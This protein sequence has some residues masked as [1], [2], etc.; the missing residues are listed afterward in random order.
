MGVS[1]R[2]NP[3]RILRRAETMIEPG[4]ILNQYRL[5]E[6]IGAGGMGE[7]WAAEDTSLKRRVAVKILP[8]ETADHP[9]RRARF[10]REAQSVA[11]LNHP[12]IVTIHSVEECEGVHFLTM[13]CVDG[14]PLTKRIGKDGLRLDDFFA[15]AIPLAD[16]VAA[17]H[18]QGITHRDLKPDNVMIT[19]DGRVKVLDFGLAKLSATLDD[20]A[21]QETQLQTV[22]REGRIVGTVNYMSPEQAEGKPTD[23]RSDVFSL[24]ILIY[25]MTTGARPFSGD[26]AI[27]T[28]TSILR[29]TPSPIGDLR[30]DLPR[31]L[32]RV[33]RR[34]LAKD[35]DRRYQSALELRNELEELKS[36][37]QS[38]EDLET[39]R[40][41]PQ[42]SGEIA[43]PAAKRFPVW[44]IVVLVAI[45]GLV[46]IVA[47][48]RF[49]SGSRE[50]SGGERTAASRPAATDGPTMIV[51]LPFEN[52]GNPDDEYFADGITEEIT[53]RLASVE[54]L[55]VI[56]RTSAFR[57]D[58]AQKTMAQIGADFGV[59][60]VLEG[61]VRWAGGDGDSRV[62]IIPSLVRVS[63][64]VGVWSEPFNQE[65]SDVFQVQSE[66]ASE[67]VA[68]LGVALA[69]S[70]DGEQGRPTDSPSAYQAYLRGLSTKR[71]SDDRQQW[72]EAAI[73]NFERATE[74][75]PSFALA[76]AELSIAHSRYHH[77]GFDRT[78][79]RQQLAK[80]AVDR[81]L[82]LEPDLP[83]AHKA[84][85]YYHYWSMKDYQPA[86]DAFDVALRDLPGDEELV[87]GIAYVYRRQGRFEE[88]AEK[89][90]EA[91]RL[92]PQDS[93]AHRNL[94]E[95]LACL[96]QFDESIVAYEQ[97]IIVAPEQ[98]EPYVA[99]ALVHRIR[100]GN[101]RR[102][103]E[104][105]K[106]IPVQ[107]DHAVAHG[108]WSHHMFFGNFDQ[109]IASINETTTPW[110]LVN[111]YR[112]TAL[113]LAEARRLAG[114]LA[115]AESDYRAALAELD[116]ELAKRPD[117][118]R[119]HAAR[120]TTL[121]GLGRREEAIRAAE[122]A[123]EIYPIEKDAL[124]GSTQ[125]EILARV[126][127]TVGEKDR[128]REVAGRLVAVP[129]WETDYSLRHSAYWGG[130]EWEQGR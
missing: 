120:G 42:V 86:L 90:R 88:A 94:G 52:L 43:A 56:S 41:A 126:L 15:L 107:N 20:E 64:D 11:A 127:A 10:T 21:D 101:E 60:Y 99:L 45:A 22:T 36:E 61:S 123:V 30:A 75:D 50:S 9:E 63:D 114:R 31:H 28:I 34:C 109:A 7:V 91:A 23:P 53:S 25:E 51:V 46:A 92:N 111:D 70:D 65:L 59:D 104:L 58:R 44:A 57:Y 54:G 68:Q 48:D 14:D 49:D 17:A 26:T 55:G 73:T 85:G 39:P 16:A 8:P 122:R 84:L 98:P 89:L 128:A 38:G 35:P 62:R 113:A 102:S 29:D 71:L 125:L 103:E 40:I 2:Y 5:I 32:D 106:S 18:D 108:L 83:Q 97:A 66:I 95:T 4:K 72:H 117:D 121:A 19:R 3:D 1:V 100:D 12:N 6:K 67:V 119:I 80:R 130:L 47:I 76:W 78:P 118:Y 105:L 27:S 115:E 79:K 74:L 82:E 77:F 69:T 33:I 87:S 124:A 129:S 96:R 110:I 13:E 93:S 24:G 37:I 112:P 81:A 116:L